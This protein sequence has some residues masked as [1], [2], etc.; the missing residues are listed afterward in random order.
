MS[1]HDHDRDRDDGG[2]EP[3]SGHAGD[4]HGVSADADRRWLTIA[5]A[6]IATFMAAEV[7]IGVLA[8]SLALISDAVT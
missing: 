2:H 8:N 1:T 4:S 5:L 7:V 6:L 3:G